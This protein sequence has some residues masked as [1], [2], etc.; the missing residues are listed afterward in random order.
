MRPSSDFERKARPVRCFR[1]LSA[2]LVISRSPIRAEDLLY[3]IRRPLGRGAT[4]LRGISS[5]LHRVSSVVTRSCYNLDFSYLRNLHPVFFLS[6]LFLHFYR[7]IL[8]FLSTPA[9]CLAIGIGTT[10]KKITTNWPW[11]LS[12]GTSRKSIE[13]HDVVSLPRG[14]Q[15]SSKLV[16]KPSKTI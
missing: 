10:D 2:W 14:H 12:S 1:V 5:I 8:Y 16:P 3:N 13:N 7:C 11:L 15:T 9:D 4:T 6:I